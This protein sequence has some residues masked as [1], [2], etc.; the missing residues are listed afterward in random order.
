MKD[1]VREAAPWGG[2]G[3][4]ASA[5]Q[6]LPWGSD[7]FHFSEISNSILQ[8]LTMSEIFLVQKNKNE[9]SIQSGIDNGVEMQHRREKLSARERIEMLVDLGTFIESDT[10]MESRSYDFGMGKKH[11]P[12]DGVITGCGKINGRKVWL[13]SQD[14]TFLGGSLGE[15]HATRIVRAQDMAIKTKAPFISINDSGGAR[16]QEGVLSLDGYGKIF[17]A[18]VLASG[19]IPQ[20]SLVLGPCAGGAAYSPA[21]TD[22]VFVVDGISTLYITGPEVIR[23]VTG[24][25]VSQQELGGTEVHSR[26]SGNV[27]FR[28]SNE[29]ECFQQVRALLDYLPNSCKELPSRGI[30]IDNPDRET[31][32][33]D[34][35]IPK[36]CSRSYDMRRVL[37]II[38]DTGSFLEVHQE[39]APSLVTGLMR[40]DGYSVGVVANQPAILSGV[41]DRDSSDKAARFIRFCDSF[42]IPIITLVDVPGYLPGLEQEHEGIIRHGAKFLYAVAE[43]TVPKIALV[44]RKAYGGAYIAMASRSLGYDRILALPDAQIAVM[45]AEGAVNVI[46]RKEIAES[47]NPE[48]LRGIKIHK[49]K[50]AFMNPFTA[51][52]FGMVDDV[53]APKKIRIELIRSMNMCRANS[54]SI[55]K[56][57]GNIPL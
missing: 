47:K 28:C 5:F 49:Y 19:V 46:F 9:A 36:E 10:H 15:Q 55:E 22:F 31:P 33:I 23:A 16:I 2:K 38:S 1:K 13:S 53:I 35:I 48:L 14:F 20:I 32:L 54:N 52:A 25:Q 6:G 42:H 41:L 11:F 29:V 21:L 30:C 7:T 37:E 8:E 24:Q 26:K 50:E 51:A 18:N 40:L 43:A 3:G 12:G 45:G 17:R 4:E 56:K 27:H 39:F 34:S 44:L 57:H